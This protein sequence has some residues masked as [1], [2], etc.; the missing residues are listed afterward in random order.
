MN[1]LKINY[2]LSIY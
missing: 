1:F 2:S